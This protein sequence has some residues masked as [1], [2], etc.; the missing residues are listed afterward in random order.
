MVR[1][2]VRAH[3]VWTS[4]SGAHTIKT[5]KKPLNFRFCHAIN[6]GNGCL[7]EFMPFA[8]TFLRILHSPSCS[9]TQTIASMPT[10]RR[11]AI[12]R[13]RFFGIVI[14]REYQRCV[15]WACARVR[16]E[17]MTN[18]TFHSINFACAWIALTSHRLASSLSCVAQLHLIRQTEAS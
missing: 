17:I 13:N 11:N 2:C 10:T 8:C 9:C 7:T 15:C 12:Q 4:H 1:V 18:I 5:S 14:E 6:N 3:C 16:M